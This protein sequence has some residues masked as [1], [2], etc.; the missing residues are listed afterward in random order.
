MANK[1]IIKTCITLLNN[2]C[3]LGHKNKANALFTTYRH[4]ADTPMINAY[5]NVFTKTGDI[6][7]I[8]NVLNTF[9]NNGIDYKHNITLCENI[10]NG[11]FNAS[12]YEKC[13]AFYKQTMKVENNHCI[14]AAKLEPTE[15]M[16]KLKLLSHLTMFEKLYDRYTHNVAKLSHY[17]TINYML[18]IEIPDPKFFEFEILLRA[19]LKRNEPG[20]NYR[21]IIVLFINCVKRGKL[22]WVKDGCVDLSNYCIITAQFV[23]RYVLAYKVKE[24]L[25]NNEY[26]YIIVGDDKDK[27]NFL[28]NELL[29]FYPKIAGII[30]ANDEA[31]IKIHRQHLEPYLLNNNYAQVLLMHRRVYLGNVNRKRMSKAY[32]EEMLFFLK[33]GEFIEVLDCLET[34]RMY[35]GR[36]IVVRHIHSKNAL[37]KLEKLDHCMNKTGEQIMLNFR[38]VEYTI[39]E[40]VE[41]DPTVNWLETYFGYH[42]DGTEHYKSSHIF[43]PEGFW[44]KEWKVK[45][46][47]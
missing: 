8:D 12:Q 11:Y 16:L 2:C 39:D 13:I 47:K 25:K 46:C 42:L 14:E 6:K 20:W 10:M 44:R 22:H 1:E 4:L 40:F 24:L 28:L 27:M 30:D 37:V 3:K 45:Y 33:A 26:F 23:L 38:N 43:P 36:Y 21:N 41:N 35:K 9:Q 19:I 18:A 17:Y 31:K 15:S 7:D 5:L 29:Q 32:K 34:D